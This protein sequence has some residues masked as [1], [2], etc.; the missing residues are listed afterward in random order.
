VPIIAVHSIEDADGT[1]EL[2]NQLEDSGLSMNAAG[3]GSAASHWLLI[4][5]VIVGGYVVM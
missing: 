2:Q 1:K 4:V 3:R 5:I